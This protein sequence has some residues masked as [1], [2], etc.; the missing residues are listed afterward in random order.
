LS[1]HRVRHRFVVSPDAV[2]RG[3]VRFPAAIARQMRRVL[4][5]SPGDR[6]AAFDGTGAEYTVVLVS[7]RDEG[8]LGDIQA[9]KVRHSE[10]ELRITLCQ[11]LLPRDK[12]ELVLQKATEVGVAGF[13]P[14]VTERS[15]VPTS[16]LD[17]G[18]L[19]RWRRI[20]QEAAE[21]AGRSQV[22]TLAAPSSLTEAAR[23]QPGPALLAWECETALSIR[24]ALAGLGERLR[25][26]RLTLFIGPEGGFSEAE[27]AAAREAGVSV[28]SLGPRTLR[29]ETA[30]PVL[31]ALALYEA[32][33]LE[34]DR[35]AEARGLPSSGAKGR[36]DARPALERSEGTR[37]RGDAGS[38][39]RGGEC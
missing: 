10:P 3:Q 9:E 15:L 17:S 20:I 37:G 33:D 11:A 25:G 7:L 6:V 2:Q 1:R 31:A 26:G 14:L 23:S 34:P 30:G 5:L 27:A 21:Q 36:G 4:R 39:G 32:G 29:A 19:E 18:R 13:V 38:R 28:V 12:F 35:A 8:A 16:A 22:P 24:R